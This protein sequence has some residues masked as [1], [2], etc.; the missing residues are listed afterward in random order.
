MS[1]AIVEKGPKSAASRRT[2][3]VPQN[4][5]DPL[6]AH[7]DQYVGPEAE[8]HLFK[9]NPKDLDEAW[10]SARA[11]IGRPTLRLHDLR[12]T[13]LTLVAATGATVAELMHRA[14]HSSPA[15]ALRYQHATRDR[16][17]VIA[18]ALAQLVASAEVIPLAARDRRAIGDSKPG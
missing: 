16:D 2:I 3:V 12:H 6:R 15:A 1:G 7:L 10:W 11:S 13:G 9:V 4:V 17:R 8:A 5:I 14:G 18:D